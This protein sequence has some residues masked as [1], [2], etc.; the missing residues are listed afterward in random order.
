M[1]FTFP[2]QYCTLAALA[3][4]ALAEGTGFRPHSKQFDPQRCMANL[5]FALELDSTALQLFRQRPEQLHGA[6]VVVWDGRKQT[7][8]TGSVSSPPPRH[9]WPCA[10]EAGAGRRALQHVKGAVRE[11][12][13]K[14]RVVRRLPRRSPHAPLHLYPGVP[15]N[16]SP[17]PTLLLWEVAMLVKQCSWWCRPRKVFC[18]RHFPTSFDTGGA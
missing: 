11:E 1:V 13:G 6:P 9:P 14:A 18:L 17:P 5:S 15:T 3:D 12:L 10:A 16:P 7:S 4:G 8:P 2:H